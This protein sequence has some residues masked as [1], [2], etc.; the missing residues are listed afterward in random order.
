M[1]LS[2]TCVK[3]YVKN[4]TRQSY[5]YKI[6]A[7]VIYVLKPREGRASGKVCVHKYMPKLGAKVV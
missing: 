2:C 6:Y 7:K 1:Y 5:M 3:S 4:H